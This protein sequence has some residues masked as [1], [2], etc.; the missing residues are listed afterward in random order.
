MSYAQRTCRMCQTLFTP[1]SYNQQVCREAACRAEWKKLTRII[2][3]NRKQARR[4][5]KRGDA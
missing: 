1:R 5:A 4:E 2:E 3:N